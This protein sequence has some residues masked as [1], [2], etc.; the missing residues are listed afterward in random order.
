[1][2]GSRFLGT[3]AG[4][5]SLA[6]SPVL[7]GCGTQPAQVGMLTA[8]VSHT[9]TETARIAV[10]STMHTKGMS[11]SVTQTGVYD[12][13]HSRGMISMQEPAPFTVIFLPSETYLKLPGGSGMPRGKS[14]VEIKAGASLS[15]MS[16]MAG[17]FGT[18]SDPADMLA[19]L[20]PI[21][22][23]VTRLGT[24]TI[25]GVRVT[26]FRVAIDP[27][28][29]AARLPRWQ[30][31]GFRAFAR[32]LGSGTV[33]VKVWVSGQDLVR[34]VQVSLHLPGNGVPADGRLSETTDFYD[35]G[36][37]VRVAAPPASQVASMSHFIKSANPGSGGGPA[38]PPR[39][40]GTL[41]A[42]QA[43]AAEQAVRAFWAALGRN[44]QNATAQTVLPTERSC[45]RG[46]MGH[47]A[48]R[49]TITSL[50]VVSV[51][52]AGSG[53][54]TVRFTVKAQASLRGQKIPVLP[55]GPGGQW[56]VAAESANHWY[57]DLARSSGFIFGGACPGG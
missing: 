42:A 46:I 56:L 5:G 52:P 28:K 14:W 41:S 51:Q 7:A 27:A 54:A 1:M 4:A 30:R 43:A 35:F 31:A 44:D 39:V 20:R 38:R 49:I 22:T 57:V 2:R 45:I 23:S 9:A 19:S 16:S 37:A 32:S 50:R 26:K 29:A 6:V 55:Q 21:S 25:R 17:P 47:G 53:K 48:P 40:S 12:F 11:V 33:P 15:P 13:A 8:A 3:L 34:R 36:V 18:G 24:A 10:T